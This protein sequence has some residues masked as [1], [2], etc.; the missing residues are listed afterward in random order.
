[1][2][3]FTKCYQLRVDPLFFCFHEDL[4]TTT[5]SHSQEGGKL[6][7]SPQFLSNSHVKNW[8]LS[9]SKL[10]PVAHQEYLNDGT[11]SILVCICV[12]CII[13]VMH[14]NC[15][16]QNW[17]NRRKKKIKNKPII[18]ITAVDILAYIWRIL[19]IHIYIHATI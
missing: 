7:R 13:N 16:T 15:K 17:K 11:E 2:F 9:S 6:I 8:V 10:T 18:P 1:M 14:I 12:Y 3:L 19:H 5:T 4:K